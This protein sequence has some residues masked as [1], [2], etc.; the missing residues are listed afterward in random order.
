MLA[1][2]RPLPIYDTE[3]IPPEMLPLRRHRPRRC[4]SHR[5]KVG[6]RKWAA[7]AELRRKA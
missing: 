6:S 7:L 1:L 5:V 2:A 3:G 4:R